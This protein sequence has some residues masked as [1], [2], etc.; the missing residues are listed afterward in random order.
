[1]TQLYRNARDSE[2]FSGLKF[3]SNR[4][5]DTPRLGISFT[6][7]FRSPGWLHEAAVNELIVS[8]F[9]QKMQRCDYHEEDVYLN[10]SLEQ[11]HHRDNLVNA[12]VYIGNAPLISMVPPS[13]LPKSK[14]S[15]FG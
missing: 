1:M 9:R 5:T 13:L 12:E 14:G 3:G 15:P 6:P 8:L 7:R 2:V 4:R 11:L 10:I